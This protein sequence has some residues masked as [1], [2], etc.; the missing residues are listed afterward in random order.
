MQIYIKAIYF[1]VIV[2]QK[3]VFHAATVAKGL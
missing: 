3:V 1:L 2:L